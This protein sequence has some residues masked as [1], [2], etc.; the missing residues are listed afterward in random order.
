MNRL[1]QSSYGNLEAVINITGYNGESQRKLV[2][3][4]R[5]STTGQWSACDVVSHNPTTGGSMIQSV[6]KHHP[7][8]VHGDFEVIV[9]EEDG[10]LNHYTRDN[11]I[12]V[13]NGV[14]AWRLSATVNTPKVSKDRVVDIIPKLAID[15]APIIQSQISECANADGTTLETAVRDK[16]GR[17]VH[18]RCP[19]YGPCDNSAGV[20]PQ[21]RQ[22]DTISGYA[23][24]PACLYQTSP[25]IL[26]ALIPTRGG[27]SQYRFE[28]GTKWIS[29]GM[30][31]G[32]S[33]PSCVCSEMVDGSTTF[34]ALVRGGSKVHEFKYRGA[35]KICESS[36]PY[37]L[38]EIRHTPHHR[39]FATNPISVLSQ[40]IN[41]LGR[42]QTTE[43]IAFHAAGAG[44][45][46]TW[47]IL[48]WSFIAGAGDWVVSE[49]VLPRVT[50][51]PL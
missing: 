12:P 48:H 26:M 10:A 47:M 15:A 43:A 14:Y 2:H 28:A 45:E 49:V 40:A 51:M 16:S 17:I 11:T 29:T 44:W 36:L 27:I 4:Y 50:G 7:D 41:A 34:Y 13:D 46:D 42:S 39:V 32:N 20:N 33:G 18:Y 19:Q 9:L 8:Q 31:T 21:W 6:S 38:S 23:T 35:W 37:A 30:V 25:D 5:D 24:G 22:R 1:C 3:F